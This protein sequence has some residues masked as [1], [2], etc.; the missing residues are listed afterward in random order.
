MCASRG[1][2]T[3]CLCQGVY[4]QLYRESAFK[5]LQLVHTSYVDVWE[6]MDGWIDGC[7]PLDNYLCLYSR[8]NYQRLY[9]LSHA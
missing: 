1:S 4:V 5:V 3:V 7:V 2:E 6:W 9:K 8:V